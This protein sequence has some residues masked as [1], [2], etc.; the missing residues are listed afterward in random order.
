MEVIFLKIRRLT[1]EDK[2]RIMLM[3]TLTVIL[4]QNVRAGESCH[5]YYQ[6]A[7]TQN[8][9]IQRFIEVVPILGLGSKI[10]R[11]AEDEIS[12]RQNL[13]SEQIDQRR[14]GNG[15]SNLS[16]QMFIYG[17]LNYLANSFLGIWGF[18]PNLRLLNI[19]SLTNHE[20]ELLLGRQKK[21]SFQKIFK[22]F[23]TWKPLFNES[24]RILSF[25]LVAYS[26][27]DF[28]QNPIKWQ[29]LNSGIQ[30][31]IAMTAP[32]TEL[33]KIQDTSYPED[34]IR[35][36]A[37]KRWAESF[38]ITELRRPDPEKYPQ[39]KAEWEKV[40]NQIQKTPINELR[41]H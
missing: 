24:L 26:A 37:F 21:V 17:T 15:I 40:L 4:F 7:V 39:D 22:Y 5:A 23:G 30:A 34:R 33:K 38:E 16:S 29:R 36:L 8:A 41:V 14:K 11:M 3:I 12:F 6:K 1:G 10:Q 18:F 31:V 20:L 27:A 13:T 19:Q 9:A 35:Q 28:M 25:V 2:M 32:K